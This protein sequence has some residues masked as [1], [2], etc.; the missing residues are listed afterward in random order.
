MKEV[1]FDFGRIRFPIRVPKNADV[2]GMGRAERV[3]DPSAE[4]HRALAA[5]LATPPL[6]ELARRRMADTPSARAVIV[7]SDDTRP[8]PYRGE[9]GILMPVIETLM[10]SGWPTERITLLVATGTHHAMDEGALRA[11]I[12]PR[13]FSLGLEIVNH[14][15]R[16]ASSLAKAGHTPFGGD[17]LLNRH[18]LEADLKILTGLVESHFMAGVS[19]GR[20]AVCPGLLA[21]KS[22]FG[23][24]GAPILGHPRAA[25]LVLDGNPVHE[26]ALAVARMAGCDFIVNVTLDT[27]YGLTGVFA[28]ELEAA[29]A[30]AYDK[31]IT[32]VA[33]F[34]EGRYDLVITHAGYV[35]INHYQAAKG[36]LVCAPVVEPGGMVVLAA[37]HPDSDPIGGP[38]YR[39]QMKLLG[40]LGERKYIE[41]I[42]DGNR[43]FVPEQWQAQMWARLFR[44]VPPE[45][46]LYCTLDISRKELDWLPGRDARSLS[47][48]AG[49]LAELTESTAAWART[50]LRS[51]LGR[52]PRIAVLPDGPYAIPVPK[53]EEGA[54]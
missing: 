50:A 24:H 2:L 8:V 40:E 54:G 49:T 23:L 38:N 51:R 21:E 34:F 35:G 20:K 37:A 6:A 26:E 25:D 15:C 33:V 44:I 46:L 53:H 27:E 4:I 1:I 39:S 43:D 30:A 29:H 17:I 48:E 9:S 32:Y 3:V 14:D 12:D 52:E 11:I 13:V 10:K 16:D 45:D 18:Y 42:M 36:A 31:L 41:K 19:G 47:P 7:L 28:G 22:I 5:P